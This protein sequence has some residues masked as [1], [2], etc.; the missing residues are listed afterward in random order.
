MMSL[1][2]R[3]IGKALFDADIAR[4]APELGS[5]V[6]VA[7]AQ[8]NNEVY[9]LPLLI[10]PSWPTPGRTRLRR[11]VQRLDHIVYAIIAQRR[12]SSQGHT[13]LLSTLM[14]AE[15]EDGGRMSDRQL[16]DEVA[17]LIMAGHETS[18]LGLSWAW[19][20][21][22]THPEVERRLHQEVDSVLD[23][24]PPT[25][26]DLPQLPYVE[27][28]MK[29]ALRLYPPA[30]EFGREVVQPVQIGDYEVPP[31]VTVFTSPWIVQRD[32]RW[33]DEPDRFLPERWAGDLSER[34]PRF[35]YL[36]FGGG[37]RV[38]MGQAFASME[39]ALVLATVAQ[40]YRLKLQPGARVE[41]LPSLT[42]RFKYGLPMIVE[43]RAGA[44][45]S[46]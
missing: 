21:L 4:E 8:L 15:D 22:A 33:F 6:S 31:G 35:A 38:C 2:L 16:R 46:A 17:T 32:A 14:A 18:A 9:G 34:L 39:T 41:P 10:P 30:L 20:L 42:C 19:Y 45:S 3:I 25:L 36:P 5:A 44:R 11:A 43:R 12:A 29:E 24:H 26:E 37:P 28:V 7:L 13:D 40:R 1:T 23:G 27:M